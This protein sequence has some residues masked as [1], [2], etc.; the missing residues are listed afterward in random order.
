VS[1]SFTE[2][3]SFDNTGD[4]CHYE[5]AVVSVCYDSKIGYERSEW[6]VCDFGFSGGN[7]GE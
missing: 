1:K 7:G 4:I 2:V 3:S 5:R 6:V